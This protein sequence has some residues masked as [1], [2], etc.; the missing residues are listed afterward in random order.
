MPLFTL[1]VRL[2]HMVS[3][4]PVFILPLFIKKFSD[5]FHVIMIYKT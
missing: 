3:K 1:C 2:A 5:C 4:L